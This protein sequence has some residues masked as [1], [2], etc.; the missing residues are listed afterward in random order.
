MCPA[1]GSL[2][3]A[4]SPGLSPL[5]VAI[6]LGRVGDQSAVV[7]SRR[8]QVWNTIIIIVVITLVTNSILISVQLGTVNDGGAV[9][10]AVLVPISITVGEKRGGLHRRPAEGS[11]SPALRRVSWFGVLTRPGFLLDLRVLR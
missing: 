5:T 6:L 10:R 1:K 7:W 3:D 11:G 4:C 2:E 8:H 9:V